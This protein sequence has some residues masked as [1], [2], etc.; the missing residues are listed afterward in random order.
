MANGFVYKSLLSQTKGGAVFTIC[1]FSGIY[2]SA[3]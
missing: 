1:G 3:V 2:L